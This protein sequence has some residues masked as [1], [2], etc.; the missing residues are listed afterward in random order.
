MTDSAFGARL[1]CLS[2]QRDSHVQGGVKHQI[3]RGAAATVTHRRDGGDDMD[4]T[5]SGGS[6]RA[7]G[8]NQ[9]KVL[10]T[11]SARI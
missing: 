11:G 4:T 3:T 10:R 5:A 9:G 8:R 7:G 6:R 2:I 1:P